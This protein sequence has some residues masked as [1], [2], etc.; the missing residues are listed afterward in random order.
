[1]GFNTSIPILSTHIQLL[2]YGQLLR[3][4]LR[5]SISPNGYV[6]IMAYFNLNCISSLHREHINRGI[7]VQKKYS[8]IIG[9]DISIMSVMLAPNRCIKI[10]S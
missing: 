10:K 6:D 4:N 8:S 7:L 5:S 3:K 9:W 1:V 2:K